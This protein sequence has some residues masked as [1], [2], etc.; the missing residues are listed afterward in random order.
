MSSDI[1][2]R[3]EERNKKNTTT[4]MKEYDKDMV[5]KKE[6]LK[7]M[8]N[9]S[10]AKLNRR[11]GERNKEKSNKKRE[12]KRKEIEDLKDKIQT[13]EDTINTMEIEHNKEEEEIEKERQKF[14]LEINKLKEQHG[15][16]SN[17]ASDLKEKLKKIEKLFHTVRHRLDESRKQVK[18][19]K[20]KK[21]PPCANNEEWNIEDTD[22][23][24]KDIVETAGKVIKTT[25]RQL[26]E[27]KKK[28]LDDKRA[29]RGEWIGG[30]KTKK[31]RRRKKKK[32]K[33]RRKKKR[34]GTKK[35][36]RRKKSTK[37]I[38]TR[39]DKCAPKKLGET[40][41]FTCYTKKSLMHMKDL[42][43]A[44]HR[45]ALINSS[46]P[47]EIW[48]QLGENMKNT[49][50][51]ESCWLKQKWADNKL[52]KK[53]KNNTFAPT[54]P[55][56][57]KKKPNEWLTSIDILNVMRQY[58]EK[59]PDFEFLGPSPIDF[60]THKMHGECVW[61]ELCKFSL[62]KTKDDGI[63]KV[64]IIF[65]LDPHDKPGSHWV[66]AYINMYKKEIYY[67]DSYGDRT[68]SKIK[69]L[70]K[71]VQDESKKLGKKYTFKVNKKRH[72]YSDSECGMYCLHFIIELTKGTSFN[73]FQKVRFTDDLMK[74][75]RNIYFNKI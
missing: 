66:A 44:R 9:I 25:Q 24:Q 42:W 10:R 40:L 47:K 21:C 29:A 59:Y 52:D 73:K 64:G 20:E 39:K 15:D 2:R 27:R 1:Q 49:C 74:K 67:F 50:N 3:L 60:D 75:L 68:P 7:D 51:R 19:L 62:K 4:L 31:N 46:N 28:I 55:S 8:L 11:L 72:Q 5:A 32:K 17:T 65:N 35:K 30:N 41:D 53:V 58:E 12:E 54:Q 34:K 36:T 37:K 6:E 57:W 23:N 56:V 16:D 43:N 26:D 48:R 14:I 45:D 70:V 18:E 38:L 13:M 61:D 69:T 33:T 22:G 71:R 63:K